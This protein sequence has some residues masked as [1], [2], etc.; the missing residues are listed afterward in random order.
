[1]Y[2]LKYLSVDQIKENPRN[3]RKHPERSIVAIARSIERFGFIAP[4]IIDGDMMIMAGHGR[5]LA[6]RRLK[7]GVIP[8]VIVDDLSPEQIA[9]YTI[10]DN[11]ITQLSGWDDDL[12]LSALCGLNDIIASGFTLT[13]MKALE[14]NQNVEL[15]D[16]SVNLKSRECVFLSC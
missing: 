14:M 16:L 12:L 11:K 9:A 6:A 13:E 1:M 5:V 4:I 2:E 3:P 8:C 10:A 7:I 15:K